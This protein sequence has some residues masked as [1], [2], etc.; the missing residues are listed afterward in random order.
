M[1][2]F[3]QNSV[4]IY[5]WLYGEIK[6]DSLNWRNIFF[7]WVSSEMSIC[8]PDALP[9]IISPTMV[10]RLGQ[11]AYDNLPTVISPTTSITLPNQNY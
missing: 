2:T 9:T 5:F 1:K 4:Q 7:T 3:L 11:F 8:L 6:M 10:C